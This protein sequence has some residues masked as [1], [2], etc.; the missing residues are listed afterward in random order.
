[1]NIGI[2]FVFVFFFGTYRVSLSGIKKEAGV[3]NCYRRIKKRK[4][5]Q[6]GKGREEFGSPA[7][8][9]TY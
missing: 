8:T 4:G 5:W 9:T 6:G 3:S 2:S 7:Q 1:M